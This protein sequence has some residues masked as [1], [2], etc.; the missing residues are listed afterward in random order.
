MTNVDTPSAA[1]ERELRAALH[2]HRLVCEVD[3]APETIEAVGAAW[4]SEAERLGP[5]EAAR[6]HGALNIVFLVDYG[7]RNY[8]RNDFWSGL[9][10]GASVQRGLGQVF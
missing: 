7:S 6:L 4:K 3:F 10:L 8:E 5:V 9:G 1:L 2:G